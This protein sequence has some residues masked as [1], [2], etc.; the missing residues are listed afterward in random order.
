LTFEEAEK[1]RLEEEQSDNIEEANNETQ[2]A[3]NAKSAHTDEDKNA[4]IAA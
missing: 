3:M 1:Q 2:L 4:R